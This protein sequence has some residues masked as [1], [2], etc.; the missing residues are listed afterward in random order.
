MTLDD[1][2]N[3][4]VKAEGEYRDGHQLIRFYNLPTSFATGTLCPGRPS[5]LPRYVEL[6]W[7]PFRGRH[8]LSTIHRLV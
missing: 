3:A 4:T 8:R 5:E 7:R 1:I 2:I 6:P